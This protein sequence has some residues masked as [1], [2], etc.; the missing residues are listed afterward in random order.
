MR[1]PSAF[2]T[3]IASLFLVACSNNAGNG[4]TGADGG[5]LPGADLAMGATHAQPPPPGPAAMPDGA[6]TVTFAIRKLYLGTTRRD[7]TPDR[8]KAW[9]SYGY[10]IDGRISTASSTDLCMPAGNAS[11]A[12]VYP[13][14]DDGIDNNFGKLVLPI[15]LGVSSDVETRT[16][17][18]LAGGTGTT[19]LFTLQMLGARA[20]YNPQPGL[21]Y[22]GMPLGSAPK[23]DGTDR[24][25]VSGGSVSDATDI[26]TAN[27][28]FPMAYLVGNI[29]V[30][31]GGTV[32]VLPALGGTVVPLVI[33]RATIS[34]RLS[35]DRA[36]ATDGTIAGVL[37]TADLQYA[38][39]RLA[40]AFDH[41]FCDPKNPTLQSIVMQIGQASD[42]LSD[43]SQDPTRSCDGI[44]IGLGFEAAKVQL[45]DVA[46]PSN[47]MN[48]CP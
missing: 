9:R 28:T 36:S 23:F 32:V 44:S 25:D 13:D 35:A 40:G 47:A 4:A 48:P 6:G 17:S 34:M 22:I 21:Y 20:D 19:S 2:G 14:G 41:S 12:T 16:N 11:P 8:A 33:H 37:V 43:G 5:S 46:G 18:A 1:E 26:T 30:A 42:I 45:G 29:W 27:V 15:L 24:F 31:T 39:G 7:G 10:D 3:V 38:F